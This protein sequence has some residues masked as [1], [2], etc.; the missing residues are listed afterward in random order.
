MTPQ[1]TRS[2]NALRKSC[3]RIGNHFL[4]GN[5]HGREHLLPVKD[6]SLV[7]VMAELEA[8]APERDRRSGV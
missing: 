5:Y 4:A 1:E 3:A 8:K 6:V 2:R 7:H